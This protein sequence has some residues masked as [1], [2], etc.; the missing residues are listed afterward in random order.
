MGQYHKVVNLTK[1]QYIH[2]HRIDNG[3]KLMEQC[4]FPKSTSSALWL[5][6]ACSNGRG[7]GDAKEHDLIGSW[8]ADRIVVIGDYAEP[9]D[10]E[11]INVNNIYDALDDKGGEYTDISAQVKQM[12]DAEFGEGPANGFLRPDMVI[13]AIQSKR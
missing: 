6:L 12:L 1:K 8:A 11:G 7:G 4:G 2:A 13:T 10:V 9:D 5:L 3:L